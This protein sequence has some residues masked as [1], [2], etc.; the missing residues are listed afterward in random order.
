MD[1]YYMIIGDKIAASEQFREEI[2]RLTAHSRDF[3]KKIM[4]FVYFIAC[5]VSQSSDIL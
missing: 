4:H 3:V 1:K 5:H 2:A